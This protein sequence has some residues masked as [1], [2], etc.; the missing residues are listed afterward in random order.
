MKVMLLVKVRIE[1]LLDLSKT[2]NLTLG[3][4]YFGK[5]EDF[6]YY[7]VLAKVTVHGWLLVIQS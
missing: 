4:L 3:S 7:T 2:R 5:R 1:I 6:V